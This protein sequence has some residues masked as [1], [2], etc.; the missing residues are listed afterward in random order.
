[1]SG[2]TGGG[3]AWSGS[4]EPGRPGSAGEA[5][6]AGAGAAAGGG[7]DVLWRR[8]ASLNRRFILQS[9]AK[10]SSARRDFDGVRVTKSGSGRGDGFKR[11]CAP[12]ITQASSEIKC[13]LKLN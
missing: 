10:R 9:K 1:M 13:K 2:A 11:R 6:G 12:T 4:A 5:A 8:M 3:R 7:D